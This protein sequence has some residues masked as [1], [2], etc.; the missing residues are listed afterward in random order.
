[1]VLHVTR[2]FHVIGASLSTLRPRFDPG[3]LNLLVQRCEHHEYCGMH[4]G[5]VCDENLCGHAVVGVA[6]S[7]AKWCLA[8]VQ[9]SAKFQ[10]FQIRFF[11]ESAVL[12]VEC[13]NARELCMF[14]SIFWAISHRSVVQQAGGLQHFVVCA[15]PGDVTKSKKYFCCQVDMRMV[16]E[17][18][19]DSLEQLMI[20]Q[21]LTAMCSFDR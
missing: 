1:M 7:V 3:F 8:K 17:K 5:C 15:E 6:T 18:Y 19:V 16:L 4:L 20:T 9:K 12:E 2:A 10:K 11:N 14:P 21:C 13:Q